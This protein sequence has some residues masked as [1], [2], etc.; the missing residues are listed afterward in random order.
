MA[1]FALELVKLHRYGKVGGQRMP[2]GVAD[3]MRKSSDGKR[4]LIGIA[5]VAE[6]IH[7]K[8]AGA[9]VMGK[10][11][12]RHLAKGVVADVLDDAAAVGVGPGFF[13]L[14]LGQVRIAAEQQGNDGV[15]P[16]EV[17]QLLVRKQG[18]GKRRESANEEQ[19]A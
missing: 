4:K 5:G 9:H 19:Q 16:G 7:D 15:V 14:C 3:V 6:E 2:V 17:D 1:V 10:V 8:I 11:A 12:E 18:I 13:Q